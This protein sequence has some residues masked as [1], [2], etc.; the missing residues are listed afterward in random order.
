MKIPV[1]ATPI[2]AFDLLSGVK[3]VFTAKK[4]IENFEKRF[5]EFIGRHYC[6]TVGSGKSGFYLI[7]K[8]L[9]R[10]SDKKEV[11]MPAYTDAGLIAV[12]RKLGLEVVLCDISLENFNIDVDQVSS[13]MTDN[14]LC[15]LIVHMFGVPCRFEQLQKICE[16]RGV[17]IIE[18][19]AQSLGSRING[20]PVGSFGDISFFSFARGKNM[21]TYAGGAILTDSVEI[22]EKLSNS[23]KE[24]NHSSFARNLKNLFKITA[25][26]FAVKPFFYTLFYP[27]ISKYKSVDIPEHFPLERYTGIQSSV[28]SALMRKIDNNLNERAENSKKIIKEFLNENA[29]VMLPKVAEEDFAAFN[30]LPVIV[31]QWGVREKIKERLDRLGIEN[32]YM[33]ERP[34]HKIYDLNYQVDKVQFPN[35]TYFAEHVITIPVHHYLNNKII[36]NIAKAFNY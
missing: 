36:K 26:S 21:P 30:R 29:N 1:V 35:A 27:F 18:D 25:L 32:S 10:M 5:S 34:L 13:Y 17:M 16:K 11:I 15:V 20:K 19:C 14:T 3:G 8:V 24:L 28:G 6:F 23:I 12:I 33:Y 4:S 2:S 22:A 9:S 7:L 31:K